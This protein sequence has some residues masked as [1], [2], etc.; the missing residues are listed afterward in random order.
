MCAK[1]QKYRIGGI[2]LRDKKSAGTIF[3][4]IYRVIFKS[5]LNL[6]LGVSFNA[7]FLSV[8]Q[9]ITTCLKRAGKGACAPKNVRPALLASI[10]ASHGLGVFDWGLEFTSARRWMYT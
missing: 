4:H 1:D 10:G 7:P 3:T 5:L 6:V 9:E 2:K 8:D